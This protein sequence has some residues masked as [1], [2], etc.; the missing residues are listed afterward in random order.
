VHRLLSD[1]SDH[2][3]IS[4]RRHPL[5][6]QAGIH[7]SKIGTMIRYHAIRVKNAAG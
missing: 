6:P 4:Q 3:Y 1:P 7:P 2:Q 5:V